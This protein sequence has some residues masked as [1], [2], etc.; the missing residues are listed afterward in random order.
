MFD[1]LVPQVHVSACDGVPGEVLLLLH[2]LQG[3]GEGPAG[4]QCR[5]PHSGCGPTLHLL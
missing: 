3:G 2:G 1:S 5:G 4:E